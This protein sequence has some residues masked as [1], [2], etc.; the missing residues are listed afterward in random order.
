[1]SATAGANPYQAPES[2]VATTGFAPTTELAG[3][4]TRLAASILDGLF[5]LAFMLPGI[6][7]I[8]LGMENLQAAGAM[9]SGMEMFAG[10]GGMLILV[11][12]VVWAVITVRLVPVNGWTLGKRVCILRCVRSDGRAAPLGRIFLHR[13]VIINLLGMIPLIGAFIS[14][15]NILFI[16]GDG[17]RCLH[18]RIADTIV[19]QA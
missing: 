3:R 12:F 14:I 13:N 6:L 10:A 18:D 2:N 8:L 1:M 5:Y 16:F 17:R 19:V 11:G 7:M 15:G 4:G 9:A